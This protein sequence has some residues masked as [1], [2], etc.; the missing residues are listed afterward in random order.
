MEIIKKKYEILLDSLDQEHMAEKISSEIS[1]Y[2][3][4]MRAVIGRI[5]MNY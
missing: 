1:V 3:E 5:E 4:F 2:Y